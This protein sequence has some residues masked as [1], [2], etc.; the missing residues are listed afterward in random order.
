MGPVICQ[1]LGMCRHNQDQ[2][3]SFA[4][5]REYRHP[6]QTFPLLSFASYPSHSSYQ[7]QARASGRKEE[8]LLRQE[9]ST[10]TQELLRGRQGPTTTITIAEEQSQLHARIPEW[11]HQP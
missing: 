4:S 6:I 11:A 9:P 7:N 5:S 3:I 10:T 8:G 2:I 1:S